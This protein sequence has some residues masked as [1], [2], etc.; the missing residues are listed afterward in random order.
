MLFKTSR[1]GG[2]NEIKFWKWWENFDSKVKNIY[3]N[4]PKLV[5][6]DFQ[7]LFIYFLWLLQVWDSEVETRIQEMVLLK[8][9][10]LLVSTFKWLFRAEDRLIFAKMKQESSSGR[11]RKL[12]LGCILST[13][14]WVRSWPLT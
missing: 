6:I 10:A 2:G 14:L 12:S 4:E 13:I 1:N 11:K 5:Q 8:A 7:M 3:L 9:H